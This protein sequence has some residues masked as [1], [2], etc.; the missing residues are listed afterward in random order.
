VKGGSLSGG[1]AKDVFETMWRTRE[2]ARAIVAREGLS[3]VSDEAAIAAAVAEVIA[4]SAQQLA[5]YRNG[6]TSA[7]GWFVGQV[8]RKMGGKA[9]PQVVQR[10][11]K[12]ALDGK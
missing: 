7:L 9:N 3:Q 2:P 5:T 6:K 10:L 1:T 11:L 12:Q 4:A 8:M